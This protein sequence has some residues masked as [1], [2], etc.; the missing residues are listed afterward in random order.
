MFDKLR[1]IAKEYK[2]EIFIFGVV[3]STVVVCAVSASRKNRF[4]IN[5]PDWYVEHMKAT[6][7]SALLVTDK[8]DFLVTLTKRYPDY[9]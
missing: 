5:I 3:A 2:P 4:L 7:N 6:G 9:L 1:R 8:G